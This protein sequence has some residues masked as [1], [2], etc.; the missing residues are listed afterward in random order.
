MLLFATVRTGTPVGAQTSLLFYTDSSVHDTV[1]E[2]LAHILK[3]QGSVPRARRGVSPADARLWDFSSPKRP[4]LLPDERVTV[5]EAGLSDGHTLLLETRNADLSWPSEMLAVARASAMQD[6]LEDV[7]MD[8]AA[9]GKGGEVKPQ[10]TTGLSNL[11]NTCFMN[12]ALQCLSHTDPLTIY[13]TS[14]RYY[15]ELNPE[16]PLGYHGDIARRYGDL[17]RCFPPQ[18]AVPFP[19]LPKPSLT[20]GVSRQLWS[21]RRSVAPLK[22]RSTVQ[23]HASRFEGNQQH[24]AQELLAFV[25]DGLHEDLNRVTEKPYVERKDSEGRPDTVVAEEH[26]HNHVAR[27]RSVMVDLFHGQLRSQLRCS[28]CG[29]TSV[30]FDPF[31]SLT[32]PLPSEGKAARSRGVACANHTSC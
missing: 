19:R 16:N 15:M 11:G 5:K 14:K 8:P 10:G 23:Q 7:T 17:V 32:M 4:V 27:N 13:F 24:D 6:K 21:G 12:A 20:R 1:G 29:H 28:E 31:S 30:T 26:W 3:H 18:S 25:L 22:L 9:A 2:L